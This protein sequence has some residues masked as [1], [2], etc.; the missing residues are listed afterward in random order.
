[1]ASLYGRHWG[2]QDLLRY[3]GHMDQVAGIRLVEGA[4]GV[5]RGNRVLQVWMGGGLRF[6]VLADR[7]LDIS[8]CN[9]KGISLTWASPVGEAH[10]AYYE[11]QGAGWLRSF[12]GGLLVTCG[13]DHFGPPCRD[14]GEDFGLHG[15]VSNLPARSVGYS[16]SWIGDKYEL[17]IS[18]EVR[19]TQ[20]FGE[21]LVLRRRISTRLGSNKIRIEDTVTNEGFSSHPHMI[22]YHVNA[23]FPLLCESARLKIDVEET[24]PRDSEAATGIADWMAFQPPTPQYCEQVFVHTPVSDERGWAAVELENPNLGLGLRL[25]FDKATLPYLVEWKMMGEGL[26]VLGIEPTNCGVVG[27]RAAARE[28]GALPYLAAGE[29]RSY[30]LE[31]DVIEYP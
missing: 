17:E 20:V 6:S 3:V 28:Q 30:S 8:A 23:G 18:G 10:P 7:A 19:Q 4:D 24:T 11:A 27:G 26:Y 16:A 31:V 29:S 2:R 9:Y 12:Q 15:R 25:T 5:E 13:L 22:L 21:N 14:E 1:M